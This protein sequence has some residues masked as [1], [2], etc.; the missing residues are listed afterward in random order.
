MD[1]DRRWCSGTMLRPAVV[2]MTVPGLLLVP[3]QH[4]R[5]AEVEQFIANRYREV[6]GAEVRQFMPLL[7][8]LL[9][10]DQQICAAAGLRRGS[11]GPLFIE[12][13]LDAPAETVLAQTFGSSVQRRQLA[14][15]GHL[16][17][18]GQGNGRRLFP[19]LA[20]WLEGEGIHWALF[21]A[22]APLRQMFHRMQVRPQPLAPARP[23]RLGEAARQWGSY[24]ETDPWVVGGP[25]SLG[26]RLLDGD[27]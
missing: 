5:R 20:Q 12:Q 6:Y 22:T 27:R 2:P 13:Y 8:A 7:F 14:E 3:P 9:T 26:A 18:L 4:P 24:Y 1:G 15:I 11:D 19:L 21:A 23:E 25:L 10:A 17:G 16:S